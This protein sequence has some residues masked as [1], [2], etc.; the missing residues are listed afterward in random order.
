MTTATPSSTSDAA[1]RVS[2]GS[3]SCPFHDGAAT[4]DLLLAELDPRD[5]ALFDAALDLRSLA[6]TGGDAQG[7][8]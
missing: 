2:G 3:A 7:A 8:G 6:A 5:T 4:L 1:R